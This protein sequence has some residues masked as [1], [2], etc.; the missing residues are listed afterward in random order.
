MPSDY[1]TDF[2]LVLEFQELNEAKLVENRHGDSVFN[3]TMVVMDLL[4][5]Q[6]PVALLS[7]L[8]HDLGKVY[9]DPSSGQ[10]TSRFC[11]HEVES[12]IIA[13]IKLKE[14]GSSHKL[15]TDVMS[16]VS[17]HMYDIKGRKTDKAIRRF[18]AT[19]GR[20]NIEDW[21][22]LRYADSA[23]YSGYNKYRNSII[24][25]FRIRVTSYLDTQP[26]TD[27]SELANPGVA[28][29]MQIEGGNI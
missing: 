14:W 16:L 20:G 6:S 13:A 17:T 23:A 12:C 1:W 10:N 7:A 5:I 26:G 27:Q 4:P 19:V 22:S 21:F 28:G 24:E 8:F 9:I 2:D 11:G 25:P 18:V 29:G 15:T 3:H